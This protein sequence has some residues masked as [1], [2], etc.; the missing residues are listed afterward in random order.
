MIINIDSG[1]GLRAET[2]AQELCTRLDARTLNFGGIYRQLA[3]E[4]MEDV[5]AVGPEGIKNTLMD[6]RLHGYPDL[7]QISVS[8]LGKLYQHDYIVDAIRE[9]FYKKS[10]T[11]SEHYNE[12]ALNPTKHFICVGINS[13]FINYGQ[14]VNFRLAV[15]KEQLIE[16]FTKISDLAAF[17]YVKEEER[18]YETLRRYE[19]YEEI[20]FVTTSF[21][22]DVDN[23][24]RRIKEMEGDK[25]RS[26]DGMSD[27]GG[28]TDLSAGKK[29][30]KKVLRVS[31][32]GASK[33]KY[34]K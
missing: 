19:S 14:E 27:G 21:E 9:I 5:R 13:R 4:S 2:T 18:I 22:R 8:N 12:C 20:A 3:K 34:D 24:Y 33:K 25:D 6:M 28:S 31:Y 29:F 26:G 23:F 7:S 15:S 10:L 32:P 30:P 1:I 11:H 16:Y 17:S